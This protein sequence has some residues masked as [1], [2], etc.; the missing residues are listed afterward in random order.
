MERHERRRAKKRRRV[1][2]LHTINHACATLNFQYFCPVKRHKGDIWMRAYS[3]RQVQP[4]KISYSV[5]PR[6]TKLILGNT[7]YKACTT[8]KFYNFGKHGAFKVML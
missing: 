5:K 2:F 4:F 6:A 7:V 3:M 8:L 1:V